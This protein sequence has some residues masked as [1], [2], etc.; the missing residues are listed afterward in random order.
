[1]CRRSD[2]EMMD[3]Q[4]DLFSQ[5]TVPATLGGK[6]VDPVLPIS[7]L[8]PSELARTLED[9]E[10]NDIF[11][12]VLPPGTTRFGDIIPYSWGTSMADIKDIIK[13]A[14]EEPMYDWRTVDGLVRET[15]IS[16]DVILQKIRE[17][18][19]D[20]VLLRSSLLDPSGQILITTKTHYSKSH[21]LID[22]ILS[23]LSD[24]VR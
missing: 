20:G 6:A 4:S 16:R 9:A 5:A 23:A 10:F 12:E 14:L 8:K 1:V 18:D 3:T 22:R 17:L 21:N 24:K 13:A 7:D 11:V 2:F 19:A 15:S